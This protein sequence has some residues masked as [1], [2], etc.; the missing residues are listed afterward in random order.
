MGELAVRLTEDFGDGFG[1]ANLRNMRQFYLAFPIR[2]ALRHE[3][4]WTH[5]RRLMRIPDADARMWYM[6]AD[7]SSLH[8]RLLAAGFEGGAA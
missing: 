1:V 3:L 5:Y 8:K 2:D 4:S 6:N 7:R